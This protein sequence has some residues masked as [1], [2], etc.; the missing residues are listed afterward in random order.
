M[1]LSRRDG[2]KKTG[3]QQ[4]DIGGSLRKSP[5]HL[6]RF[7]PCEGDGLEEC[8]WIVTSEGD[9]RHPE[10]KGHEVLRIGRNGAQTFE[11]RDFVEF[12]AVAADDDG[13]AHA[14]VG[15]GKG[16]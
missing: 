8:S 6:F 7:V 16:S 14:A 1:V 10:L 9:L 5:K 15:I 12:F 13:T 4:S 2:F 3:A 11:I